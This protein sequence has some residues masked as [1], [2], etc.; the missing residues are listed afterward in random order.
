MIIFKDSDKRKKVH[1]RQR[2][3]VLLYPLLMRQ[4][5]LISCLFVSTGT[6]VRLG[7]NVESCTRK[8]STWT[9]Q[10]KRRII[11]ASKI[12]KSLNN[13]LNE[14]HKKM[15]EVQ[16]EIQ[17]RRP[18]HKKTGPFQQVNTRISQLEAEFVTLRARFQQFAEELKTA[19]CDRTNAW[20]V[21]KSKKRTYEESATNTST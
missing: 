5:M 2:G 20:K 21:L 8:I 7:P 6:Q 10:G 9:E 16:N 4:E 12:R 15:Q 19:E 11:D 1:V 14:A 17:Y 3:I 18:Q 13:D